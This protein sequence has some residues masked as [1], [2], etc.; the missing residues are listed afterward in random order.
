MTS[1]DRPVIFRGGFVA[2]LDVVE[3]LLDIERRGGR[4][5]QQPDGGFLVEPHG[6][7]TAE[8]VAFIQRHRA[9]ARRVLEYQADDSHL[10]TDQTRAQP[11]HV[12]GR[13]ERTV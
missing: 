7:L 6:L 3:R 2:R 1:S 11:G 13:S 12:P 5:V 8:D 4:F 9:E 10:F